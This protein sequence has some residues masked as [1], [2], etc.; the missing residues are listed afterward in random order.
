MRAKTVWFTDLDNTL[1]HSYKYKEPNDVCVEHKLGMKQGFID[2]DILDKLNDLKKVPKEELQIIPITTRS[3]E[4]YLRIKLFEIEHPLVV[5]TNGGKIIQGGVDNIKYTHHLCRNNKEELKELGKLFRVLH[6]EGAYSIKLVDQLFICTVADA[7][8]IKD[9]LPAGLET[10][11]VGSKVYI[12]LKNINKRYA[13]EYM[14]KDSSVEEV[15]CSGDSWL[16][17]CMFDGIAD[18]VYTLEQNRGAFIRSGETI[19]TGSEYPGYGVVRMLHDRYKDII[20][21]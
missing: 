4:Q 14:L 10:S 16:D 20:K 5:T 17:F 21:K 19:Y 12:A 9:R 1:V 13:M 15:I 7:I 6:R 3:Y 2:K 8:G 11:S 18:K